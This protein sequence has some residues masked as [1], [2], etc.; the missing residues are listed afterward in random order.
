M[1][2]LIKEWEKEWEK[3]CEECWKEWWDIEEK[4]RKDKERWEW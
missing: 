2:L 1:K 3:E 4:E